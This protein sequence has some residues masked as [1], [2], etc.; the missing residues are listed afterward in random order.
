MEDAALGRSQEAVELA[1]HRGLA[2]A[3]LADDRDAFAGA[4]RQVDPVQRAR[5]VRIHEPDALEGERRHATRPSP[6]AS[7]GSRPRAASARAS[8][9]RD[10][11]STPQPSSR[12]SARTVSAGPSRAI[13]PGVDHRDP[14]A[15]A[16]EKVGL[17]LDDE[18]RRPRPR[19]LAEALAD[20]SRPFR[21]ELRGRF[22]EDEV[23][24][25]HRK[26]RGDDDELCLPAGESAR[27]AFGQ[28]LDAQDLERLPRARD[29]LARRQAEVHR[30]ERDLLED[31]SR[32]A[33]QLRRRV[34]EADPDPRRE[35]VQRLAVHRGA[36][37]PQAATRDRAADRSRGETRRD[38]AQRRLARFVAAD[39]AQ[40]VAVGER[41]V[42]VVKDRLRVA[43]IAIPDAAQLEHRLSPGTIG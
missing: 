26:E 43:G 35:L 42:D 28:R 16:V 20:E 6:R 19:E 32:H 1:D 22:V 33:R 21:V 5:P 41:Q 4:D 18:Q 3:V 31:G 9:I 27:L 24:R 29:R 38:E 17:V 36:V 14:V 15:Q 30:T 40:H 25:P 23:G 13:R 34:L 11:G 8:R 7:P 12:G 39:H 10:G 37:D 2:A